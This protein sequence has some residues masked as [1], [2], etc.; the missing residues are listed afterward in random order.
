MKKLLERKKNAKKKNENEKCIKI[1]FHMN[2]L[3]W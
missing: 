2:V 1:L 3:F